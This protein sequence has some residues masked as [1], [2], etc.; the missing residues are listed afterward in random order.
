MDLWFADNQIK[1]IEPSVVAQFFLLFLYIRLWQVKTNSR[2][3]AIHI[4]PM[5]SNKDWVDSRDV[6]FTIQH[7]A[8]G[9]KRSLRIKNK[10]NSRT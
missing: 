4:V 10:R 3:H 2:K 7:N 8:K 9:I 5:P 1:K 6:S